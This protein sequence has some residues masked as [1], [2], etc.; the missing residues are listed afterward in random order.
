MKKLLSHFLAIFCAVFT[1]LFFAICSNAAGAPFNVSC[2]SEMLVG[3]S[4]QLAISKEGEKLDNFTFSSSDNSVVTVDENG[5]VSAEK[6][7]SAKIICTMQS[8]ESVSVDIAVKTKPASITLSSVEKAVDE[9]ESFNLN[10]R[11]NSGAYQTSFVYSSTDNSVA[12]VSPSGRVT[13]VKE[14][15]AI[16]TAETENGVKASCIVYVYSKNDIELNM[17]ATKVAMDYSNVTKIVYGKSALGRNLEAFVING[18]GNNS[19]TLFCTFAVHGFEDSYYRDGK[20]LVDAAND[21]V[22]YFAENPDNLWDYRLVIVPCAN[23]DGTI[24]GENND[25]A[26]P[27]A[28]GRCTADNVDMNRD[29]IAG[30]FK[31]RE[32]RALRDLMYKY[33]MSTYIDFHGWLDTVLGDPELVSIYRSTNNLKRDQSNQYGTEKG[34]IMGWA[35]ANLGARSA[36]VELKSPSAINSNSIINGIYETVRGSWN[37]N[38]GM[39]V[40]YSSALAAPKNLTVYAKSN[41]NAHVDWNAASGANGYQVWFKAEDGAWQTAPTVVG[42][43]YC[44]VSGLISGCK[45]TFTVRALYHDNS[46]DVRTYSNNYSDYIE[47]QSPL[48]KMAD[49]SVLGRADDGSFITLGWNSQ[50]AADGYYVYE[51]QNNEWIKLAT[52]SGGLSKAYTVN[53]TESGKE[54]CFAIA[55]FSNETGISPQSEALHTAAAC[56]RISSVDAAAQGKSEIKISWAS[57]DCS[58]YYVQWSDN[59]DFKSN[60]NGAFVSG[61]SNTSY[62]ASVSS[63]SKNYYVRVRAYKLVDSQ[64]VFGP[65]SEGVSVG[66]GLREI[67]EF[68]VTGRGNGGRAL[69]LDWA[70]VGGATEYDVYDV[71]NGASE[72][73]GTSET[74]DFTFTDLNPAWEYDIKVVAKNAFENVESIYRVCAAT[75]VVENF[76]AKIT[77]N[78]SIKAEWDYAVCHGYYIQWSTDPTFTDKSQI[79]GAWINNTFTTSFEISTDK[80]ASEYYVRIRSWKYYQGSKIFSDFCEPAAP[81]GL[82][83][84]QGFEVTGRG[85]SGT[86]LWLDWDDVPKAESYYIYDVTN[87]ANT[88]KGITQSSK[89]TFVD[90]NPAWEYDIKVVA[91]NGENSSEATYRICAATAPVENFKASATG[92]NTI[93]ATWDY[94]VCH[95]YYIQWS[96]DPTFTDKSQINGAWI[97]NTFTTSFEISTDK[98]ASEYYVRI[99]SWKYYQGSKIFSDFCEP[100]VALQ[101]EA[102]ADI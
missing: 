50:I 101:S 69:W 37:K 70:D 89:F 93:K 14:G 76:K 75:P 24:D 51:L 35:K 21:I 40:K 56:R 65:F 92:A 48:A 100:T 31:A 49:L 27:G 52:V 87:G 22:E 19:K 39:Q 26:K 8:G 86:A 20:L 71:T 43:T 45:Y 18:G 55:A 102:L 1:A 17:R 60:C 16:I 61:K 68:A 78:N 9:G 73:K 85:K 5:I 74:S 4:Q 88:L 81:S 25:R 90:L 7:G 28:F 6:Q 59:P 13:G 54:Y 11:V 15:K 38:H 57:V 80:P 29:F 30:K 63:N 36:L 77:D 41:G 58:G 2:N 67:N 3:K 46:T 82:I 44:D 84:P 64:R 34:Y 32:S 33:K 62:V 96:T 83:T 42:H 47:Y 12:T 53:G 66:S 79:N 95:G 94:A 72:L 99:R 23:P 91:K 97:N 98:P 10:A